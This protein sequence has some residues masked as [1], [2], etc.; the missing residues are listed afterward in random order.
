[1]QYFS[2]PWDPGPRKAKEYLF[3]GDYIDA[4]TAL[5]LGLVNR[6]V[7]R[8]ELGGGECTARLSDGIWLLLMTSPCKDGF[9]H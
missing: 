9:G 8:A 4:S 7:P 1:V 6:V 2:M 5:D 3:T